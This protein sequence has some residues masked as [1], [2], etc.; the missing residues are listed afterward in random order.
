MNRLIIAAALASA[1]IASPAFAQSADDP[2]A[3]AAPDP[4]ASTIRAAKRAEAGYLVLKA[5]DFAQ[6]AH[7]LNRDT[8]TEAN[9][10]FSKHPSTGKLLA[11]TVASGAIQYVAF[12]IAL[13]ENPRFAL[14]LAQVSLGV[15]G[16]TVA[17]NFR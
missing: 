13:K 1:S 9:P 5:V 16:I 8:C 12:R 10:L 15:Q 2:A 17:L 6:T 7:C 3:E 11:A 14:R 4:Y